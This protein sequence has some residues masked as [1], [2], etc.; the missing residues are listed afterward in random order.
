MLRKKQVLK[1]GLYTITDFNHV[2]TLDSRTV[3][4]ITDTN[5]NFFPAASDSR[6]LTG[7]H[8]VVQ[9]FS[10]DFYNKTIEGIKNGKLKNIFK[11]NI[12]GYDNKT[13]PQIEEV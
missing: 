3:A 8:K 11:G 4:I 7:L 1:N 9:C 13:L 10:M 12:Y 5:T 2:M 6:T